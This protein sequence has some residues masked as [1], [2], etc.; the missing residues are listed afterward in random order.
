MICRRWCE[1]WNEFSLCLHIVGMVLLRFGDVS[2]CA[3]GAV[4]SVICC[5]WHESRIGFSVCFTTL[6]FW[7]C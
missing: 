5:W 6:C 1:S 3:E 4:H 2:G 7:F